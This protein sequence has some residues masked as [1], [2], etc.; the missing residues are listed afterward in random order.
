MFVV[1]VK[2]QELY[3]TH[4]GDKFSLVSFD[5]FGY[6]TGLIQKDKDSLDDEFLNEQLPLELGVYGFEI[7]EV[8]IIQTIME[9][10][11]KRVKSRSV[12][13]YE[14]PE[15]NSQEWRD[16]FERGEIVWE[17]FLIR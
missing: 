2:G 12:H 3:V 10:Y 4:D 5:K 15:T 14:Y 7:V 13:F 9:K 8:C 11:T 6:E 16:L 1:K 17:V